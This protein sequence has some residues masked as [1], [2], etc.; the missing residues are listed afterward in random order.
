ML[1]ETAVCIKALR[2]RGGLIEWNYDTPRQAARLWKELTATG[3]APDTGD[4]LVSANYFLGPSITP[5]K[6][7][8]S[9]INVGDTVTWREGP[10]S[11]GVLGCKVLELG[12]DKD[13]NPAARINALGQEVGARIAHLHRE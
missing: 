7:W 11:L 12:E 2:W 4:I 6:A 3:R 1:G 13:G 5:H 8:E 9:P 10:N